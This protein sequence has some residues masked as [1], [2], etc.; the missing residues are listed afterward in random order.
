MSVLTGTL[1]GAAGGFKASARTRNPWLIGLST[2]G[3]GFLGGLSARAD[4]RFD[5][6]TERFNELQMQ[7][8]EQGLEQGDMEIKKAR[9]LERE[10]RQSKRQKNLIGQRLSTLFGRL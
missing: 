6:T 9:R 1:K 3:G 8:L 7:Q 2:F 10:E 4:S 5:E